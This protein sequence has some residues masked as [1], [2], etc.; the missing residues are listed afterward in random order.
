MTLVIV[1]TECANLSSVQFA[2][3]RLGYQ[4]TITAD[5]ALIRA[6]DKVILPGVGTAKAA[7][8]N[9]HRLELVET[10]QQ[11]TQPL[12]GIC[13]GMQLLTRHSSEG[14]VDCLGVIPT[15]TERLVAPGLALPHMGWNP[16]RVER[17]SPLLA[18]VDGLHC[19]FVHSFAVPVDEYTLASCDYGSPFAAVIQHRN[20]YGAQF[21]PERSGAVGSRILQ[22]FLDL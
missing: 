8:R 17:E 19:Y 10:L 1:N 15:A 3:E 16:I 2:C 4:P 22:N 12:L 14:E 21:H 7:M 9:L 20:F 5:A 11:L 18:G 6:A 13:L